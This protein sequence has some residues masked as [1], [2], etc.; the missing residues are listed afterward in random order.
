MHTVCYRHTP[1]VTPEFRVYELWVHTKAQKRIEIEYTYMCDLWNK[2]VHTD[3]GDHRVST[4]LNVQTSTKWCRIWVQSVCRSTQKNIERAHR[5]QKVH[6]LSSTFAQNQPTTTPARVQFTIMKKWTESACV[7]SMTEFATFPTQA[8]SI[9]M[10]MM[11]LRR[12]RLNGGSGLSEQFNCGEE[13]TTAVM[14]WMQ[15]KQVWI[16]NFAQKRKV[17]FGHQ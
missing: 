10:T 16:D 6:E 14:I 4:V 7:S 2:I 11:I 9:L 12:V 5:H 8:A 13:M 17:L 3:Q 15:S 1:G